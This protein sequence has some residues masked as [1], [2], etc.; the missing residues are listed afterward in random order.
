MNLAV[1]KNFG[2]HQNDIL[3]YEALLR[4]GRAKSGPIIR[5]T[6]VASSR[7]YESLALLIEKGLASYEVKNNIRY[8]R[9]ESPT[10]LLERNDYY[11]QELTELSAGINDIIVKTPSHN[12]VNVFEK[13]NGFWL[14]LAQHTDSLDQGETISIISFGKN[15]GDSR[16]LRNLFNNIDQA[17]STKKCHINILLDKKL[18]ETIEKDRQHIKIYNIRY[19]PSEYFGPTSTSVSRNDVLIAVWGNE[20]IALSIKNPTIVKSFQNNF[21]LLWSKGKKY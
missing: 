4:F 20:P 7:V 8:Y 10:L 12:E 11:R 15:Y 2:L 19:L 21:D 13:K 16:E 17:M 14:A 18:Q 9:P 5:S 1:L 3:V 6:E